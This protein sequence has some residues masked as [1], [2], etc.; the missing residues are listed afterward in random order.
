MGLFKVKN[1][2]LDSCEANNLVNSAFGNKSNDHIEDNLIKNR[3]DFVRCYEDALNKMEYGAFL[4]I[5]GKQYVFARCCDEGEQSHML[6]VTK[7]FLEL[8]GKDSNI[9]VTQSTNIYKEYVKKFLVFELEIKKDPIGRGRDKFF[10]ANLNHENISIEEYQLFK[11]FYDEYKD[12][13]DRCN[14]DFS[15]WDKKTGRIL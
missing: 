10:R 4:I 9:S 15:I 3:F 11:K 1:I 7:A 2:T 12:V 8:D 13:I 5:T 6:S 14:F